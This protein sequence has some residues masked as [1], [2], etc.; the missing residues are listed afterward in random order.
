MLSG[1]VGGGGFG[2][3]FRG[4]RASLGHDVA[5]KISYPLPQDFP[6]SIRSSFEARCMEQKLLKH[7][8]IARVYASGTCDLQGSERLFV[9]SD[10]V[11]GVT[12][13][14]FCGPFVDEDH[15][16]RTGRL[17]S[18]LCEAIAYAHSVASS[19]TFTCGYSRHGLIHGDIKPGNVIVTNDHSA[20]LVDFDLINFDWLLG[21]GTLDQ[22]DGYHWVTAD[23]GANVFGTPGYMAPEL[24][25]GNDISVAS[26]VYALGMTLYELCTG[27]KLPVIRALN[28]HGGTL[29]Q[30]QINLL[31]T[32]G[33]PFVP[34]WVA[35][36]LGVTLH[37]DP[38]RRAASVSGLSS[39]L[40]ASS[41]G[42]FGQSHARAQ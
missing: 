20:K 16:T 30:A 40:P 19:E 23:G 6:Y 33:G 13:R 15:A 11:G 28:M 3:V 35:S 22:Q 27:E 4:K 5:L 24:I 14:H 26:D 8:N 34:S 38:S 9:L 37:D 25:A 42:G 32:L 36:C 10:F 1:V 7:P 18:E 29:D 41:R 21:F 2:V 12:M 17:F 39:L 31:L